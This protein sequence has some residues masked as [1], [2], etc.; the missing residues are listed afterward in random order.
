MKI[1][2][3]QQINF[4]SILFD[5]IFGLII[6]FSLD[7]IL[8]VKGV[9]NFIFYIFTLIIVVHWWLIFKSADDAFAEEVTD[10]AVDLV[11]GIIYVILLEYVVLYSKTANFKISTAFLIS[12]L[13]IDLIWALTWR[14]F[15]SWNTKN[16]E[17]IKLME[18]ELNHNIKINLVTIGLFSSL[19]LMFNQL[20]S[21][22]YVLFFIVSYLIYIFLTFKTR[23]IDLKI[24]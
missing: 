20:A 15:G 2:E 5:T 16:P 10:S 11:F 23:I 19:I 12:L 1:K 6:F 9:E 4:S 14:Y 22:L 3:N 7:S 17:K 18:K 13:I 21:S 24:F 8:E